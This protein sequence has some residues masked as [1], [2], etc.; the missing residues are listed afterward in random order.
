MR[1]RGGNIYTIKREEEGEKRET[2]VRNRTNEY[3]LIYHVLA[4]ILSPPTFD[5][6][7]YS[8]NNL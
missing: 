3:E 8:R 6:S 4:N 5:I 1:D 7:L 2:S